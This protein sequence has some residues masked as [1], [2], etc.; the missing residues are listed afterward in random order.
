M[1]SSTAPTPPYPPVA[2]ISPGRHE[3]R[4][5]DWHERRVGGCYALE[6]QIG[7]GAT[8]TVW[9]ALDESTGE[10]VAIKL[11]REE[12]ATQPKTVMRFVQERAILTSLRHANIV[13]VRELLTVGQTLGL[14]MDL[15]PGGSVR[16]RLRRCG[17]LRPAEAASI[18]AG[19]AAALSYA[20]EAGVV[21]RDLKP[22]N[23]LLGQ[24][25]A[26]D[27]Q[28]RLTDFGIARILDS[29]GLT[30]TGALVGT[31]NYL[32]P[33][34]INGGDPTPAADVYAFG[35]LLYELLVGRPPYSGGP[36]VAVLGRHLEHTPRRYDG[37]PDE[38]WQVLTAC[39]ERVPDRRPTAAHLVGRMRSLATSTAGLAAL[40]PL[41][42]EFSRVISEPS[43]P[44][45]SHRK[46]R[47]RLVTVD[48]RRRLMVVAAVAL[49]LA[50]GGGGLLYWQA[51]GEPAPHGGRQVF[52][53]SAAGAAT[54]PASTPAASAAPTVTPAGAVSRRPAALA[55]AGK[56][57]AG[58][59]LEAGTRSYGPLRC[60]D[61]FEWNVGHPA[62][63]KPCYATGPG[64]RLVGRLRALSGVRADVSLH[65]LDA[66]TGR[67]AAGPFTCR[68]LT[69]T[70][71]VRERT[72]GPFDAKPRRGQRYVV[73]QTWQYPGQSRLSP[74]TARSDP[75]SW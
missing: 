29:P 5:P 34:V 26:A 59:P 7:G 32:A 45:H 55:E 17:P 10:P 54:A 30:T 60:T 15:V 42:P 13:P 19:V 24:P 70:D 68:N 25:D 11:L 61:R 9:R 43:R 39:I 56:P 64:I 47:R 41:P 62:V 18:L 16:D 52:A 44:D 65:L 67:I 36:S 8:G 51:G 72:C 6:E 53:R 58:H 28:V 35:V 46:S 31:P 22:D 33:E 50:A 73:V 75:F 66:A 71:K 63:A 38:M 2:T 69:F 49:L 4:I 40:P 12:L 27:P 3:R 37:I 1:R 74:G 57:S 21:H 14:V 23:I 20:H 48:G